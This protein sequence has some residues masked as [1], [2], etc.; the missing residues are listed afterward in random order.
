MKPAFERIMW[1]DA[2]TCK[3][4]INVEWNLDSWICECPPLSFPIAD[5]MTILYPLHLYGYIY[6]CNAHCAYKYE[7]NYIN[8]NTK[9][10][11]TLPSNVLPAWWPST[12]RLYAGHT[13]PFSVRSICVRGN[14]EVVA[15]SQSQSLSKESKF[16]TF[17]HILT[18]ALELWSNILQIKWLIVWFYLQNSLTIRRPGRQQWRETRDGV[19]WLLPRCWG[20][21]KPPWYW[22]EVKHLF[23]PSRPGSGRRRA[24]S[25][26]GKEFNLQPPV[27]PVFRREEGS[28]MQ[29]TPHLQVRDFHMT[30]FTLPPFATDTGGRVQI[31]CDSNGTP[32]T[33]RRPM[34]CSP[35]TC[36]TSYMW[37]IIQC[38]NQCL[39]YH[40]SYSSEP[41]LYLQLKTSDTGSSDLSLIRPTGHPE[42]TK[43]TVSARLIEY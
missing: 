3:A 7:R 17:Q 20:D 37:D 31:Q 15:M 28:A 18:N 21:S 23:R 43:S 2:G 42:S 34:Q 10:M 24:K 16:P 35:L 39:V 30:F 27:T 1:C 11:S 29:V 6:M 26:E 25:S 40:M 33:S 9:S 19:G 22:F 12:L 5:L 36:N 13:I 14:K 4:G 41:H 38:L 8:T 32:L